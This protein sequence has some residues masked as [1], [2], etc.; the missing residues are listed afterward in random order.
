[1]IRLP[2][3]GLLEGEASLSTADCLLPLEGRLPEISERSREPKLFRNRV[4]WSERR[5]KKTRYEQIRV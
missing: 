2:V 4:K 5:S 1:M 3:R